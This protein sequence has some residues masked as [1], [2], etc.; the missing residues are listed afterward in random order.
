MTKFDPADFMTMNN[1]SPEGPN[2][3][4]EARLGR[5]PLRSVPANWKHDILRSAVQAAPAQ[6]IQRSA[7]SAF[8]LNVGAEWR[9]LLGLWSA[10]IAALA[11][12]GVPSGQSSKPTLVPVGNLWSIYQIHRPEVLRLAALSDGDIPEP[13]NPPPAFVPRPHSALRRSSTNCLG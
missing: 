5:H 13:A 12:L 11:L 6:R 3:R 8:S 1:S 4:F 9:W 10:S 7:K 2:D